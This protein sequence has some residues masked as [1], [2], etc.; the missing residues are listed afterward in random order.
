MTE[1]RACKECER[2][3]RALSNLVRRVEDTA[4]NGCP[5]CGES[6]DVDCDD[7]CEL[8]QALAAL[9]GLPATDRSVED[10]TQHGVSQRSIRLA[11][12]QWGLIR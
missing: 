3:W 8:G 2:L 10:R 12:R 11:L 9:A 4:S 7:H 6:D 5:F 1:E